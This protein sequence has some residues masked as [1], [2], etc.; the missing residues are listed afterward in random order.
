MYRIQ[1]DSEA[2]QGFA[3]WSAAI[4]YSILFSNLF[5]SAVADYSDLGSKIVTFKL[6][7]SICD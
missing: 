3:A 5:A 4:Y 2:L 6:G 7:K 1:I